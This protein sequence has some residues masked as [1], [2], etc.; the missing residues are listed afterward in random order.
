MQYSHLAYKD[1]GGDLFD[2]FLAGVRA[3]AAGCKLSYAVR[4]TCPTNIESGPKNK[5]R[6]VTY[7]KNKAERDAHP[8]LLS[9]GRQEGSRGEPGRI[10]GSSASARSSTASILLSSSLSPRSRRSDSDALLCTASQPGVGR[11]C[12]H[13]FLADLCPQGL[14]L[15]FP[16]GTHLDEVDAP[17]CSTYEVMLG[18]W[19]W[20][21][22]P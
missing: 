10:T 20:A 11:V 17:L 16:W 13:H 8:L 21:I 9:C 19:G 18:A 1:S 14:Q 2:R 5:E 12:L 4:P 6:N 15:V 22:P 3:V 7:R